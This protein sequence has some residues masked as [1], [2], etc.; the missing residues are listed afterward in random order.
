MRLLYLSYDGMLEPLG[1]SQVLAYLER[2]SAEHEIHLISF[3]KPGDW[4]GIS[5]R[6]AVQARI[7]AAGIIWKPLRYHKSPSAPAT[8]YDIMI[9][10]FAALYLTLRHRIHVLHARSYVAA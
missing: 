4:A 3:E 10:T 7:A 1:Q 6:E 8:A 2:L 5:E 9:G